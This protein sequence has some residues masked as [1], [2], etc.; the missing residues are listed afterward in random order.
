MA[1]ENKES[2]SE[3]ANFGKVIDALHNKSKLSSLRTY[4]G[5]MAEFI[6]SKNE[7]VVSIVV[8]EKERK[9]EREEVQEKK[10]KADGLIPPTKPKPAGL[11]FQINITIVVLSLVL[12]VGGAITFLYV[13]EFI[14]RKP[15]IQVDED[16]QI[17]PY[18]NKVTLA[19]VSDIN[20]GPELWKLAS[21]NGV[22][23][24]K[25]SDGNGVTLSRYSDF[26]GFLK[27]S[28]PSTLLRT[29]G[30]EYVLGV[31]TQGDNKSYFLVL[32]VA[33]FGQAFAGMLEWEGQMIDDLDFLGTELAFEASTGTPRT[34]VWRDMIVKNKD[35]RAFATPYN[36]VKLA[37]TFLDKNTILIT[38][39]IS[40]IGELSSLYAS[41][42]VSR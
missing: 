23:V 20:L 39:S 9:E 11:G 13:Y 2:S 30:E 17:I 1:L 4:Q 26:L 36:D 16:R 37:Y 19:N 33:D 10:D 38:N 41:R 18:N 8:K 12:I 42:S 7:S 40:A 3:D 22:S 27:V 14:N 32:T 25:V 5:D 28:P 29:L 35:T 21:Q 24:V 6:K 34:F 15:V 31:T